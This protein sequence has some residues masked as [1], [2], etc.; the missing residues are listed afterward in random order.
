MGGSRREMAGCDWLMEGRDW[1]GW[2]LGGLALGCDWWLRRGKG[3]LM[4]CGWL[5]RRLVG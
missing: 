2:A 1:S 3:P 4:S 5:V